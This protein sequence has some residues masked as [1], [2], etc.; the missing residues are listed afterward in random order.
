M[1]LHMYKSVNGGI[2]PQTSRCDPLSETT[3]AYP[4]KRFYDLRS[5]KTELMATSGAP[6]GI[7]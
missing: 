1:S 3:D 4:T 7:M 6:D 5:I 2:A